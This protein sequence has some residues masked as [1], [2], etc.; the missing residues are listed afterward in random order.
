MEKITSKIIFDLH[1]DVA[2]KFKLINSYI[3]KNVVQ[4]IVEKMDLIFDNRSFYNDIYEKAV[5][6]F[7]GIIRLHPF[8]DGN[9]RTALLTLM[10]FLKINKINF[11]AFPSDVR[12]TIITAQSLANKED[13][14]NTLIKNIARWI[15]SHSEYYNNRLSNIKILR[16]QEQ[17]MLNIIKISHNRRC[18]QLLDRVMELWMVEDIYP[19]SNFNFNFNDYLS[20]IQQKIKELK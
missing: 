10:I 12:F 19:D 9:K 16:M 17:I 5:V 7:E 18:P 1:D 13:E 15:H 4:S 2:K 11:N 8:I 3:N 14:I 20:D 6:L